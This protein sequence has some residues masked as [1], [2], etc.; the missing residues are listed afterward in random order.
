MS[1][2]VASTSLVPRW[3]RNVAALLLGR[4][5]RPARVR[6]VL[7]FA[8]R[9]GT[10]EYCGSLR[11]SDRDDVEALLPENDLWSDPAYDVAVGLGEGPGF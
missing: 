6:A 10:V 9:L 2:P 4:G 7:D 1:T 11:Y 5:Y 3:Q 8:D